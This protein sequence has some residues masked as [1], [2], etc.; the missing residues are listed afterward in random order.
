MIDIFTETIFD[1]NLTFAEREILQINFFDE[2]SY[3]QNTTYTKRLSDLHFLFLIR[4]DHS[5][6]LRIIDSIR[7]LDSQDK[8]E[9]F[10]EYSSNYHLS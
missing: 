7:R 3:I 4:R 8:V 9:V 1:H 2:I 10:S 6:R 5:N